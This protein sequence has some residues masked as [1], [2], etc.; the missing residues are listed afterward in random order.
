MGEVFRARDTRLGREVAIKILRGDVADNAD[1]RARFEREARTVAALSHPNIVALYEVGNDDGVEYTVS[2]LVDGESLRAIMRGGALPVRRVVDLATQMADG[3][4][5]AHAAGIVHRDLK[6]ENV[7]VTREGR[8]KILDFGLARVSAKAEFTGSGTGSG[9]A[10]EE[11]LLTTAVSENLTG[12]G[13]VLGTAAYMSPEQAKGLEA[14][15]HSDQFSFGLICYEMLNGKQAFV[16]DSAVETMAAIVRDEPA[17]LDAKVPTALRWIVERCLEKDPAQ[18]YDS[19]KDLYQQLRILRDHFSEV[20]SSSG[21]STGVGELQGVAVTRRG[22]PWAAAI[23]GILVALAIGGGAA[24]LAKPARRNLDRYKFTP[25]A[26]EAYG[27][28]V[29]SRDGKSVAYMGK[30]GKVYEVFVRDLDAPTPQQ[31]TQLGGTNL[32]LGWSADGAHIIFLHRGL[33]D[34]LNSQFCS[35]SRLGGASTTLLAARDQWAA[36]MAL[37]PDG[38]ALVRFAGTKAGGDYHLTVSDP[39]GS[40]LRDYGPLPQPVTAVFN[41]PSLAFSQDGKR[42][43]LAY[44]GQDGEDYVW[45][46]PYPANSGKARREFR[47]VPHANGTPAFNWLPDGKQVVVSTT[48]DAGAPYHLWLLKLGSEAMDQLTVGTSYESS[49]SVAPNGKDMLY[50]ET[51]MD[52]DVVS[53]SLTTGEVTPLISTALMEMM[54]Q[55]AAKGGRLTY[56][57]DREG[58]ME[59]WIREPDGGTWPLVTPKSIPGGVKWFMAP[60][61]SP[62]GKRVIFSVT[63]PSGVPRLWMAS[64]SGGA[65][66]RVTNATDDGGEYPGDWSPDG[67]QFVIHTYR[68]GQPGLAVVSTDGVAQ[69]K[70]LGT[71]SG[72]AMPTTPSWSP[73]G[74]RIAYRDTG[75]YFFMDPDGGH[76]RLFLKLA[77]NEYVPNLAFSKDGKTLYGIHTALGKIELIS[78][79]PESGA[80]KMIRELPP[81]EAALSNLSP[82]IRFSLAPD[83]QS[84]A[85]A[86]GQYHSTLWL[87]QGWSE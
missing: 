31:V 70:Q 34:P 54:P 33:E 21:I 82:T 8:V 65:P 20:A 69:L 5:A 30:I 24:W 61:L 26:V 38:K 68:N 19:T 17:P 25:F 76:K 71:M 10:M 50:L 55:Y 32:P 72:D 9:S 80:M 47:N 45:S 2:E 49:P 27:H 23:A 53:I 14:D 29:W 16:R 22:M 11:T 59:I 48:T 4:A 78:V 41:G 46:L 86:T 63:P 18:R 42:M 3:M 12:A 36:Q 62:D 39:I 60:A 44:D 13:V 57:T 84:M 79:D 1:R 28:A 77:G 74:D 56:V 51:Q 87:F 43:L 83:G 35:I 58:P 64:L 73:A 66:V 67:S 37:S 40:P 81:T 6:P 52:F 15:Y 7:M 85:Y 75:G